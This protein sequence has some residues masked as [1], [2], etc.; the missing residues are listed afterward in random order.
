MKINQLYWEQTAGVGNPLDV[1]FYSQKLYV[2]LPLE[3][4]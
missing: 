1:T 3:G 4:I 2:E